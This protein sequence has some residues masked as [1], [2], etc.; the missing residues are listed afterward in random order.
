MLIDSRP[1][2]AVE[3]MIEGSSFTSS[4]FMPLATI[5]ATLVSIHFWQIT[6]RE[7]KMGNQIPGP[8]TL[9]IIGNAH[10]FLKLKNDGND[11]AKKLSDR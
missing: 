6:R 9:P 2:M 11:V 8:P 1:I 10:T 5:L 7:R 4:L 3:Q